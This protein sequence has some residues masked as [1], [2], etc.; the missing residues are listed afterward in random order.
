M[1]INSKPDRT[2]AE[3]YLLAAMNMIH[4]AGIQTLQELKAVPDM[5]EMFFDALRWWMMLVGMTQNTC[6]GIIRYLNT[7]SEDMTDGYI[8]RL[9]NTNRCIRKQEG[10]TLEECAAEA[11]IPAMNKVLAKVCNE[12]P[13]N[14]VRY[15][16]TGCMNFC[17]DNYRREHDRIR[18][19]V[20]NTTDESRQKQDESNDHAICKAPKAADEDLLRQDQ[21][22]SMFRCF[23]DE[24]NFLESLSILSKAVK[25]PRKALAAAIVEGRYV[26]IVNAIVKRLNCLLDGDFTEAFEGMYDTARTFRLEERLYDMKALMGYLNRGATAAKREKLWKTVSVAI[27]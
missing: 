15:L 25:I 5:E 17:R 13:R 1:M 16:M 7:T 24:K 9:I 22:M 8:V 10:K 20:E 23:N 3:Q 2:T 18:S 6:M 11:N 12:S 19:T 4:G 21:M 26:Q 27:A 14:A